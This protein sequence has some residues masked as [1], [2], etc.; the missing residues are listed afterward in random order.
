V[1]CHRGYKTTISSF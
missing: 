1:T